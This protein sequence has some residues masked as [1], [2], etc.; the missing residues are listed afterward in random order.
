[1]GRVRQKWP[2]RRKGVGQLELMVSLAV[3]ALIAVGL[4]NV[5]GFGGKALR[6]AGRTDDFVEVQLARNR[7]R[8]WAHQIPNGVEGQRGWGFSGGPKSVVFATQA[9]GD[10]FSA[11]YPV[12]I[13]VAVFS[14]DSGNTALQVL[15]V[16][17]NERTG[18]DYSIERVVAHD[19]TEV[20][21]TY[22]GQSDSSSLRQWH[23]AWEDVARLPDLVKI[24]WERVD[25]AVDPPLTLLP[26]GAARQSSIS[27]SSALPPG[28]P[29]RP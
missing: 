25:G 16:G 13:S 11:S 26:G 7:L 21:V 2:V 5:V 1:M 23:S 28:R 6:V 20:R 29:S 18:M 10:L 22:F 27:L 24:E 4:A 3:M 15:A 19:V 17:K 12:R 14:S 9:A 8:E